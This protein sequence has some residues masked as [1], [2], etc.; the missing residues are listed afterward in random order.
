MDTKFFLTDR[1][2]SDSLCLCSLSTPELLWPF[3]YLANGA[4]E[5]EFDLFYSFRCEEVGA[6]YEIAVDHALALWRQSH[7]RI[8]EKSFF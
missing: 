1:T 5:Y 7:L 4:S 3:P 6:I 2:E 8:M